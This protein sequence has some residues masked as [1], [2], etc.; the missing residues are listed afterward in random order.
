MYIQKINLQNFGKHSDLEIDFSKDTNVI[1]GKTG[2]GKSTIKKAITWVL[3]TSIKGDDV[4]KEGSK[5]T[6]VTLTT[7]KNI[8]VEKVKSSSINRYA[9]RIPNQEE[10]I[11]DKIGSSIP[12]EILEVI[13][14]NNIEID[15]EVINLNISDQVALPFLMDKSA[16]FRMKLFNKLT[17]ND[18]LDK[19]FGRFNKDILKIK[20]DIASTEEAFKENEEELEKVFNQ[21]KDLDKKIDKSEYLFNKIKKDYENYHK[22]LNLIELDKNRENI[23]N[24]INSIKIPEVTDFKELTEKIERLDAIKASI[25]ALERHEVVKG[26]VV[27]ELEK[28]SLPDLNMNKLIGEIQVFEKVSD[29]L[30]TH[31]ENNEKKEGLKIKIKNLKEQI[32]L[33]NNQY[34][35]KLK[36]RKICEACGQEIKNV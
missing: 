14:L 30:F 27:T 22:L 5:K 29:L 32:D 25:N 2:S 16:T 23:K 12:E 36:E 19:L 10:K 21:K 15:D 31:K 6:S 13:N 18:V 17:G 28:I 34:N 9:L 1:F 7:D 20:R 26:R 4:R 33:I 8:E 3:T 35:E 24:K 11:F